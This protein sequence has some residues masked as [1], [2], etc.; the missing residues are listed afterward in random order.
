[1]YKLI[2]SLNNN[3]ALVKDKQNNE[4]VIMGL[5]ITFQ[6]KKGDLIREEKV[7]KIFLIKNNETKEN[8]LMLL[9]DVPLDF[10][11][12]TFEVIDQLV[13]QF[14]YP[15]QNYI[16]VTLTDHLFASYNMLKEDRYVVSN[17]PELLAQYPLEAEMGRLALSM[18]NQKLAVTF[19]EDEVQRIA[20]HFINAKGIEKTRPDKESFDEV[21]IL[22]EIKAVLMQYGILRSD[23]NSN[24]YD[25]LMIHLSYFLHGLER[26]NKANASILNLEKQILEEYPKAYQIGSNIYEIIAQHTHKDLFEGEKLYIVLHIQRLL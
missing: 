24:Y 11:S 6:K 21:I 1:M 3:A 23:L 26:E 10:V 2:R 19:P 14:H 20:L 16:Y 12:V 18:F 5:G 8:L 9:K 4:A 17:L 13:A 25:R 15:V 7:E 22:Q